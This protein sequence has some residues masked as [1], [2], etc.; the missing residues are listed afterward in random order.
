MFDILSSLSSFYFFSSWFFLYFTSSALYDFVSIASHQHMFDILFS[1]PFL[2]CFSSM[3]LTSSSHSGAEGILGEV[4]SPIQVSYLS[5][6]VSTSRFRICRSLNISLGSEWEK[7]F[8]YVAMAEKPF[9]NGQNG[10]L[11]WVFPGFGGYFV[12]QSVFVFSFR[13]SEVPFSRYRDSRDF[14]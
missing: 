8:L 6:S 2:L 1:L 14:T 10:F 13:W 3:C 12:L 11:R 7:I 4:V 5:K 9:S